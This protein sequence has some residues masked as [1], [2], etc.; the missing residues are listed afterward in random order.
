[1]VMGNRSVVLY[2]WQWTL[3]FTH[4]AEADTVAVLS[5]NNLYTG[6]SIIEH[7][8][9]Y[10]IIQVFLAVAMAT[11]HVDLSIVAVSNL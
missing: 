7:L 1:M 4:C 6:P 8:P 11:I 5:Y 2:G 3:T 10:H 9:E